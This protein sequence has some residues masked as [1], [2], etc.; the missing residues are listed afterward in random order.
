M[1]FCIAFDL[2]DALEAALLGVPRDPIL[3]SGLQN[4]RST[5]S[6]W[7]RDYAGLK[8]YCLRYSASHR[9]Y[10][11]C[12]GTNLIIASAS[13]FEDGPTSL[14]SVESPLGIAADRASLP[15]P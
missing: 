3:R 12:S 7:H 15:H 8:A 4:S 10:Q 13:R 1:V 2:Y 9:I 14:G 6:G 11:N 5:I